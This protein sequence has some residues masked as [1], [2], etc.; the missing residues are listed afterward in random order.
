MKNLAK[1]FE[2]LNKKY[3]KLDKEANS[4][5]EKRQNEIS[6]ELEKIQ[7]E[8]SILSTKMESNE[9]KNATSKKKPT[10]PEPTKNEIS[11]IKKKLDDGISF[12]NRYF[13]FVKRKDG[14]MLRY[15]LK[16][17]T[18]KFFTTL[19]SFAK[20]IVRFTKRGW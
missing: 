19:D 10:P 8:M 4:A 18:Y 6:L 14:V 9:T 11:E 15:D 3:L 16:T 20:A 12:S 1:K 13:Q 17:G 7:E 2:E 5:N